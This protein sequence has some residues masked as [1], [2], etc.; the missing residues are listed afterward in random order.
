MHYEGVQLSGSENPDVV[1]AKI[2]KELDAGRLAGPFRTR[3]FY[4]FRIFLLGVVPGEFRLIHHLSYPTG[5]SINDGICGSWEFLAKTD[6]KNVFRIIPIH[7]QDYSLLD[8]RW[9]NL[10]YYDWCM[11]IGCSSGCKTF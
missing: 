5:S 8:I 4:P 2:K 1:D 9:R 11:P 10:Y 7:P 3:P 6:V